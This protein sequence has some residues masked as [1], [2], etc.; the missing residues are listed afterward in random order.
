M[1]R[2]I[3]KQSCVCLVVC[4]HVVAFLESCTGGFLKMCNRRTHQ[5]SDHCV[6]AISTRQGRDYF[7]LT[8]CNVMR[9]MLLHL[10]NHSHRTDKKVE[11]CTASVPY[12]IVGNAEYLRHKGPVKTAKQWPPACALAWG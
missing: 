12:F 3:T 10:P 4:E 7:V 8:L 5:R 11:I 2:N 1:K 6:G 9:V